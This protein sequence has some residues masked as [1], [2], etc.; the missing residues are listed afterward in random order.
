MHGTIL[1]TLAFI[2]WR[3]DPSRGELLRNKYHVLGGADGGRVWDTIIM[4][5]PRWRIHEYMDVVADARP[6]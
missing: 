1:S 3:L 4:G 2:T 6:C 5:H